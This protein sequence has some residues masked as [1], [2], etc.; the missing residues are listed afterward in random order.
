MTLK[1]LLLLFSI[2]M[3]CFV[4]G[5]RSKE[6]ILGLKKGDKWV[7]EIINLDKKIQENADSLIILQNT[8]TS[9]K[10]TIKNL[11]SDL[12]SR[13]ELDRFSKIGDQYWMNSN[14]DVTS[15]NDGTKL[16]W[17]QSKEDWD[18]CYIKNIPAYCYHD[19]DTSKE[20]GLLY[21]IHALR[22]EKL[23]PKGCII[24]TEI[25]MEAMIKSF[26]TFQLS[27]SLLLKSKEQNTWTKPGLDLFNMNIK[28]Y[29]V[30]LGED[31]YFGEKVYFYCETTDKESLVF[32]VISDSADKIN[33]LKRN[34]SID[35]VHYGL[36]VR[37]IKNK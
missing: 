21:N 18:S 6:T 30:R 12:K 11:S 31:R 35:N 15:L 34:I 36:Y 13:K 4:F 20:N 1:K 27:A 3:N 37:C 2:G 10:D 33:L 32:Y 19:K 14:L 5:Q 8:V 26:G 23:A 9:Q 22:S 29:G 17:A 16:I 25:D 28:P 7:D 24:P